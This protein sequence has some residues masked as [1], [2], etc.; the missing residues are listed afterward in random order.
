MR[1][2][3]NHFILLDHGINKFF[4]LSETI[5]KLFYNDE[6]KR[7]NTSSIGKEKLYLC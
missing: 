3:L 4:Y 7:E 6:I 1:K 5:I 2:L